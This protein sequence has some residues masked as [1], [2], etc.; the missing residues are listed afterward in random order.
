MLDEV[1]LVLMYSSKKNDPKS[2]F[3]M[4]FHKK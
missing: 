1:H 2:Q 4:E 3:F